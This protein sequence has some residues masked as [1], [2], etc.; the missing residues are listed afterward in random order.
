MTEEKTREQMIEEKTWTCDDCGEPVPPI[1]LDN[2]DIIRRRFCL[3]P[4]GRAKEEAMFDKPYLHEAQR[5][6][7][8]DESHLKP[9]MT[10][11]NYEGRQQA[12]A[13]NYAKGILAGG[14]GW[15]WIHGPNGTHKNHLAHA[16]GMLIINHSQKDPRVRYL[17]W[18]HFVTDMSDTWD[19][20]ESD[21]PHQFREAR[22][23]SFLILNELGT[24]PRHA[25]AVRRF[26][27]LIS[28]RDREEK[29]TAFVSSLPFRDGKDSLHT[30]LLRTG[31]L[32]M[33]LLVNQWTNIFERQITQ[34]G[35]I[36]YTGRR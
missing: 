4:A 30:V 5:N 1:E 26:V 25:W 8:I 36:I 6:R 35:A 22:K 17:D 24:M 20:G 31:G 27:D 34:N 14:T 15:L 18:H 19:G 11:Q 33:E 13:L 29:P 3:C 28:Y 23:A 12:K 9:T 10:F 7:W 32:D 16:I 21:Y 2:G